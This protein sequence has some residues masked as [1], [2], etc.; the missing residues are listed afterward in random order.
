MI[1]KSHWL[2][3][4]ILILIALV[5]SI[6][7]YAR[8]D[9]NETAEAQQDYKFITTP[10]WFDADWTASIR[11]GE[12]HTPETSGAFRLPVVIL[13]DETTARRNDPIVYLQ[14][15]PGAGARLH[16]DGIKSW[17]SWM[18]Y[19]ALG[20]DIILIDTRG[21]G[22][23]TPALVCAE[24]NRSNQQLLRQHTSLAEE[25]A[26]GFEVTRACFE[27]A[28]AHNSALD[29]QHF[30]TEQS[31]RDIRALVQTLG[32]TEWNILGVSY[33]TRLALEIANQEI[34]QPQTTKLKAMVLDSIYPAGF[35]GVQTWPKVLDEALYKFFKGCAANHECTNAIG[36]SNR[37]IV[38]LFMDTLTRLRESPMEFTIRRWDGEAPVAFL[39]ND[40]RFLSAAFAATY[41]PRDWIKIA[42]AINGVAMHS[43]DQIKPLLEPFVNQSMSSDFNSLTFTAVDCADNLVMAEAEYLTSVGQYPLLQEYTRD[44]WRYQACHYLAAQRPLLRH[45]PQVPTL[46]LAGELDPV[47]PVD[48]AR[49]V[50]AEWKNTQLH[51]SKNTAHS[52]LSS[53]ACLLQSLVV[54]YDSP[55]KVFGGCL[56][57]EPETP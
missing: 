13:K 16:S 1:K 23:S 47:T 6:Y 40:H 11:C 56:T 32:Y 27:S 19:A 38:Q 20:R 25:L 54:F 39:L 2:L 34:H 52:V 55:D 21:T 46:I 48:W 5:L 29:Y 36:D 42:E 7:F 3:V 37:H 41:S 9:A 4:T 43:H 35:G 15:G 8:A 51:I 12:L 44:Q 31:A 33:G 45:Q 53:E 10:C 18:R 22:R 14:G 30:S 17:L 57:Q 50:H 28:S 24:Y 49:S 26:L